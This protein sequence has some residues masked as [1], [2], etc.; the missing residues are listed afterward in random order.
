[1]TEELKPINQDVKIYQDIQTQNY[2]I[3]TPEERLLSTKT[4]RLYEKV[5]GF[6]NVKNISLNYI[7]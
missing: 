1:M 4:V 6:G 3:G 2:S 5:S 7:Q